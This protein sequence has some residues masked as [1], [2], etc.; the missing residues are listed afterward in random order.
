MRRVRHTVETLYFWKA[1]SRAEA[2]VGHKPV[3][4]LQG[5]FKIPLLE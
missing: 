2:R 1:T 5:G 4:F 3:L